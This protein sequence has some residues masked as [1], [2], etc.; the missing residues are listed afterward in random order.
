MQG[1][2]PYSRISA[3]DVIDNGGRENY[4]TAE[5]V[6]GGPGGTTATVKV[7]SQKRK[8]MDVTVEYYGI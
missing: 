5:L 1:Q 4:S 8:P 6:E 2:V 7:K 3:I